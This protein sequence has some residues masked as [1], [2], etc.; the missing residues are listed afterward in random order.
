MSDITIV[1][2]SRKILNVFSAAAERNG[3]YSDF[4][5]LKVYGLLSDFSQYYFYTY[6]PKT[7]KFFKNEEMDI[8][9]ETIERVCEG[10]MQGL[11]CCEIKNLYLTS[12]Y[13]Q[14]AIR[15]LGLS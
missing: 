11:S 2:S 15:Y 7:K 5:N 13:H 10:M 4:T 6:D 8:I 14:Y 12:P 3:K 1:D 9:D